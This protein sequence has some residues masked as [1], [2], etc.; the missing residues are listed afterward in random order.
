MSTAPIRTEQVVDLTQAK[1]ALALVV[2]DPLPVVAEAVGALLGARP[3][4]DVKGSASTSAD[5]LDLVERLRGERFLTILVATDLPGPYDGMLLIQELRERLPLSLVL[6][7]GRDPSPVTVARAL[8]EGADGFIDKRATPD[9]FVD[10]LHRAAEGETVLA[11]VPTEWFGY[12]ADAV[13]GERHRDVHP[14]LSDR[15]REVLNLAATGLSA[16]GV[17]EHMGIA[18]RTVTTHLTNIYAKLG[19]HS[20]VA[21]IRAAAR[22][23]LISLTQS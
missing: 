16:R 6:A 8:F 5:A 3:G 11:G 18:E 20:R 10:A 13:R 14:A 19:V 21:A 17:A 12:I 4:V 7:W 22:D 23:G 15:E 2:V 1:D 9:E